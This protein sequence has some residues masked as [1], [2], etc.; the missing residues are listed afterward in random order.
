VP[1]AYWCFRKSLCVNTS[2]FLYTISVATLSRHAADR[3]LLPLYR[4]TC[5]RTSCLTPQNGKDGQSKLSVLY[6]EH[7]LYAVNI[8]MR[9]CVNRW[10]FVG[11]DEEKAGCKQPLVHREHFSVKRKFK[12]KKNTSYFKLYYIKLS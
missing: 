4:K 9:N 5:T 3:H 6:T 1:F 11:G 8:L 10:F 12:R 2:L 7:R